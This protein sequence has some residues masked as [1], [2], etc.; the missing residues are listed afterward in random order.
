MSVQWILALLVL[1]SSSLSPP[2]Q[3]RNN[4]WQ[5]QLCNREYVSFGSRKN[6]TREAEF[7]GPSRNEN[8]PGGFFHCCCCCCLVAHLCPT[9][10]NPMD[11]SPPGSSV[12]FPRQEYWSG[13]P[14]PPPGDLPNPRIELTS[15]ASF[16]HCRR[17][18]YCWAKILSMNSYNLGRRQWQPTSVLLPGKSHG[19]RSLVG[20]SP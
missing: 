4:C 13:L 11:C 15:P 19:R 10:C 2:L 16:L 14:F 8:N 17:I 3:D 1:I 9:L 6:C 20:Y 7:D 12:E 18:L 5:H